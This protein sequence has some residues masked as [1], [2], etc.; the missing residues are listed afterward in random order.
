MSDYIIDPV[1]PIIHDWPL[2]HFAST[3]P[4]QDPHKYNR[5]GFEISEA[6]AKY[7]ASQTVEQ[8]REIRRHEN[9]RTLKW[10]EMYQDWP[11]WVGSSKVSKRCIDACRSFGHP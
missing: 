6:E 8:R 3:F 7:R 11:R 4:L 1:F 5:Y 9:E 2:L 10:T